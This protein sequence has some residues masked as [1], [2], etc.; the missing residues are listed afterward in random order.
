[1]RVSVPSTEKKQKDGGG[2][3]KR[4]RRG[5]TTQGEERGI[6]GGELSGRQDRQRKT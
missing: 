2:E 1:M 5:K 4:S 3:K 6:W